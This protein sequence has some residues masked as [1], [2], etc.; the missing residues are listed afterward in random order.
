[1]PELPEVEV[2]RRGLLPH[3]VGR[4]VVAIRSS[5]KTLRRAVPMD[6]LEKRL[7]GSTFTDIGRRAKYLLFIT[8]HNDLLII[9]LGMTGKLGIFPGMS[10]SARHDHLIFGLD[11]GMELRFNDTRRFG[12]V[13]YIAQHNRKR[14]EQ[15]FFRTSGPEP[16]SAAITPAYL[17][18]RARASSQAVKTFIMNGRIIA[19]IGNIYANESLFSAGIHPG[20]AAGTLSRQKWRRLIGAIQSTLIHAI[21]CGGSTISD[22]VNAGGQRGYFQVNF[23]VYGRQGAACRNCTAA[24]QKMVINGRASYFCSRCQ[25]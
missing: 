4:Q 21:A 10:S 18:K 8:D 19:G 15:H 6:I 1:M 23:R 11:N 25:K 22:Y 9:H 14:D 2:I 16:F 3:A 13:Q 12:M 17:H 5:G 7:T 20:R 24:I